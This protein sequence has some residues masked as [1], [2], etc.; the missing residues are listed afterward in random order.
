MLDWISD[1]AL[2]HAAF[3]TTLERIVAS[4]VAHTTADLFVT[5]SRR[6]PEQLRFAPAAMRLEF[7]HG[8]KRPAERKQ[9][10]E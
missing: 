3:Y 7:L 5:I 8:R 6:L 9:R 4:V 2:R 1:P 10:P